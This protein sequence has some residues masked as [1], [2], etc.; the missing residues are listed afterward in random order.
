[1]LQSKEG[2]IAHANL[3]STSNIGLPQMK[4][5]NQVTNEPKTTDNKDNKDN[6]NTKRENFPVIVQVYVGTLTALG[7]YVLYRFTKR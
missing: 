5:W 3:P 1:M 4:L 2:F 7:L 6:K